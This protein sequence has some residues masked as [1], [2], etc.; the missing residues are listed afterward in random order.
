MP[1]LPEVGSTMVDWPGVMRPLASAASI[2]ALAMRSLT[3]PLG[4]YCSHLHQTSAMS[5]GTTLRSW[6]TGVL[7]TRSSG[8]SRR[9]RREGSAW[10]GM[11]AGTLPRL[12]EVHRGGAAGARQTL[13][14]GAAHQVEDGD[15]VEPVGDVGGEIL[16][17]RGGDLGAGAAG[18][19]RLVLDD[20][21]VLDRP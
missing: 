1:V 14:L 11:A 19:G 3:E 21:Q 2:I 17:E 8:L 9:R 7:P 16:P 20:D 6:I 10:G 15:P 5:S 18:A 12:D 4:L 13:G